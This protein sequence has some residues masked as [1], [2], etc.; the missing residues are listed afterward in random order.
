MLSWASWTLRGKRQ[1]RPWA[2]VPVAWAVGLLVIC[3]QVDA[4]NICVRL[5]LGGGRTSA[6]CWESLL[7][8]LPRAMCVCFFSLWRAQG[9]P[10]RQAVSLLWNRPFTGCCQQWENAADPFL[11]YSS[12]RLCIHSICVS[13]IALFNSQGYVRGLPE[14]GYRKC[15]KILKIGYTHWYTA[16][17]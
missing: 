3:G 10:M 5:L 16:N 13:S 14:T 8:F 1:G 9:S 11:C 12:R 7:L 17:Q 15:C 4:M 2:M 6:V